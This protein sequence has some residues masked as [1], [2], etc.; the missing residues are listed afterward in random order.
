M[1]PR[2]QHA[3][4]FLTAQKQDQWTENLPL[5][6]LDSKTDIT[7]VSVEVPGSISSF[8]GRGSLS[9]KYYAYDGIWPLADLR[10]VV[11]GVSGPSMLDEIIP[12]SIT[13]YW[14]CGLTAVSGTFVF[15]LGMRC[16]ARRRKIPGGFILSVIAN[17]NGYASLS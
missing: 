9:H 5:R 16:L 8:K 7:T 1:R 4:E 10:V 12:I 13:D 17:Q 11:A 2:D 6:V 14:I 15:W 3:W